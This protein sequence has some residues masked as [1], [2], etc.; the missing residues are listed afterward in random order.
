MKSKLVKNVVIV[1]ACSVM[2]KVLA[3]VYEAAMAAFLG[4]GPEADALYMT[5][6]VFNI[7]YPILDLGIWKVFLPAYKTKLSAGEEDKAH[8]VANNAITLFLLLSLA[9]VFFL[10]AFAQPIIALIAPGY[11]PA[12]KA[13][14]IEFLRISAPGYLLMSLASILGAMLQSHDR[15]WG[16]QLREIGTH[17]S[18]LIYVFLCF[19]YF[20]A[21]AAVTA[22]IVGSVF[23]V[24]IQVPFINWPWKFRFGLHTKDPDVRKMLS[25]LPSV[26]VTSTVLHINSLIDRMIASGLEGAVSC[27]NYGSRLMNVFSGTISGAVTTA[28][29]PEMVGLIAKRETEALRRLLSRIFEILSFF[30]VPITVFCVVFSTELVTVSFQRGA[31]DVSATALTSQ[32]FV[33][34]VLG[35]LPAAVSNILANVFYGFGDT[36]TAMYVSLLNIAMNVIFNLIFIKL[37][38]V[39]GLA[40]ATSLSALL[41]LFLRSLLVRKYVRLNY[42][43][44]FQEL[45]KITAITAVCVGG[46]W[47]LFVRLLALSAFF[48]LLLALIFC[49]VLF[50]ALAFLFKVKTLQIVKAMI[51][52]RLHRKK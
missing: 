4:V 28:T 45:G 29:Y 8:V 9:L 10:L 13:L 43:D 7:L 24:L 27:L 52:K 23:R 31:F 26:A 49:V 46:A 19:R 32:V 36:K 14:T 51:A 37:L 40:Y 16:S 44:V 42:R 2:G 17:L 34:Y 6:S 1:L 41:C 39:A 38:G 22:I 3:Y 11:D 30:I 47:L 20:G 35:M 5:T 12:K 18:K 15:F 48:R 21:Y 25:G 50:L 33:G